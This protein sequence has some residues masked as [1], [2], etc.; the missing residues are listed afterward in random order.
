MKFII[1]GITG[2]VG[3]NLLLEIIKNNYKNFN[4]IEIIALG[5]NTD[6]NPLK[7]R[8]LKIL[9]IELEEYLSDSSF[10]SSEFIKDIQNQ[11][12]CVHI[13]LSKP[14]LALDE[15]DL[16]TLLNK[17]IDYFYH[18]AALTDFR[19]EPSVKIAL[20]TI[21]V[22]GTRAIINL[23]NKLKL[24]EFI[25]VSSAY[26]CGL[27][28][29]KI[30]PT[31]TNFEQEFRN[32][33]EKT[34]L[35]AE[36]VVKE[37]LKNI[38]YKIF[39]PSTIS[40]RLIEGR[41]GSTPK[42]DV[43]YSWGAFFLRYKE[44]LLKKINA[45]DDVLNVDFRFCASKNSGLN[46]VPADFVAKSIYDISLHDKRQNESYHLVNQEETPHSMYLMMLLETMNI[47]GASMVDKIPANQ[48]SLEKFYYKTVGKIFTPYIA[49]DPMLFDTSNISYNKPLSCPEVNK[50]RFLILMDYAKSKNF[51]LL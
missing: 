47:K 3:R 49:K 4:D 15:Q 20:E 23:V 16:K 42:F 39:R 41:L 18:V 21:N 22:E 7:N 50:D 43:F 34:K 29:G 19:N 40:G 38:P 26:A 10:N 14:N 44:K 5:K 13:D 11:I 25:Y 17:E 1:T 33:Y 32:Y 51:G 45:M 48:N 8:I 6:S 46:I 28:H 12:K 24:K 2:L 30:D 27:T 37:N 35:K 9:S 31:Y 36:V